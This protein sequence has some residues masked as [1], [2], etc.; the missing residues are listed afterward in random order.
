MNRSLRAASSLVLMLAASLSAQESHAPSSLP[1]PV[2]LPALRTPIHTQPDDEGQPYGVW[3]AGAGYKVSFHDG[4]TFVPY[5][6]KAAQSHTVAWRTVS[7][8]VGT[9]ELATAAHPALRYSAWRA[10][11]DLGGLVE[12]YD[13]RDEGVEQTFVV[14]RRPAGSGDLVIRGALTTSLSALP[15]DGHDPVAFVDGAGRPL[16]HYGAAT[17][18]DA[19]GRRCEMTTTTVEGGLELRVPAGWLATAAFPLVV[20]PL[21]AATTVAAG[22]EV[23]EVA[24][25]HDP[26]GGNNVWYA[27]VRVSGTDEDLNLYRTDE[28]GLNPVLVFADLSGSISTGEPS[29]GVSRSAASVALAFTRRSTISDTTRVRVHRHSRADMVFNSSILLVPNAAAENQWRPVVGHDLSASS[30]TTLPIVFQKETTGAFANIGTSSI[31]GVHLDLA[32]AGSFG[33]SFVVAA[34]A[35][36]DHERPTIAKAGAG[37]LPVWTVGY[38]KATNVLLLG[39]WDVALRRVDDATVSG[40]FMIDGSLDRHEFTPKLGGLNGRLMLFYGASTTTQVAARP[41]GS[42][43]HSVR[44]VRLDWNGSTFE[45]PHGNRLLLS[46]ADPRIEIGGVDYD[47][48]SDSHWAMSFRSSATENVYVRTYGHTGLQLVDELVEAP[49]VAIGTSVR[50]GIAFQANDDQFLIAYGMSNPPASATARLRR[51]TYPSLLGPTN[52]G[53]ACTTTQLDW[54]GTQWIG[55]EYCGVA[56]QGA[57]SGTFTVV[58]A[59]TAPASL[60]LFGVGGVHDGCW[61][62]VPIAGPDYLGMLPPVIGTNG[63]WQLPL[64]EAI[65]D[66]DLRFQAVTFDPATNEFFSSSRLTV[67]V[68]K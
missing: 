68:R 39:T 12:A 53:S 21:L 57:P 44:G 24:V 55:S 2:A 40:E 6:G 13:V 54:F 29:L 23:T 36:A 16:V 56:M 41:A 33:G 9:T 52:S 7:A 64:P 42:M 10:E 38:Q 50:G 22:A 62:L 27:E 8:R 17:A 15:V 37:P 47:T 25:A 14:A 30:G 63:F 26:L 19:Q 66:T 18:I 67:P 28:N 11:Y 59:A 49:S 3:A 4:M 58:L 48:N 31:E 35:I 20:D 43:C 60:Q 32:G 1:A 51:L 45:T 61:L 5:V 46:Y 34:S 65:A